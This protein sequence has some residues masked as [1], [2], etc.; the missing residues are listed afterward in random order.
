[1]AKDI[2]K[3]RMLDSDIEKERREGGGEEGGEELSGFISKRR[4]R[5]QEA[6]I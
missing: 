4:N 2:L 1:M 5:G 3:N 6:A